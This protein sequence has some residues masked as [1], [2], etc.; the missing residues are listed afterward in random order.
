MDSERQ[1][2]VFLEELVADYIRRYGATAAARQAF[3][4]TPPPQSEVQALSRTEVLRF[5]SV[6]AE[7]KCMTE[8]ME[9]HGLI[10]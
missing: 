2:I 8:T 4:V 10:A 7:A 3:K 5:R 1:R 6:R 9:T